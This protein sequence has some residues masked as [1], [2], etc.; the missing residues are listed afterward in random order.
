MTA[1]DE[2]RMIHLGCLNPPKIAQ[3]FCLTF[4]TWF[5]HLFRLSSSYSR[6]WQPPFPPHY[7]PLI[8]GIFF[9]LVCYYFCRFKT[10]LRY[11]LL[12]SLGCLPAFCCHSLIVIWWNF[13]FYF[14]LIVC[15]VT[16]DKKSMNLFLFVFYGIFS[17]PGIVAMCS[18]C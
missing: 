13:K 4:W 14:L 6:G 8:T 2:S 11:L 18:R 17:H 16:A 1:D 15:W 12:S 3:S 5:S 9:R 7:T 10:S